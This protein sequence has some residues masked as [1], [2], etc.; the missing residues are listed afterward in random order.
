MSDATRTSKARKNPNHKKRRSRRTAATS[1]KHELYELSVQGPEAEGDFVDKAFR[2][3]RRRLARSIREDFCGTAIASA[4]WVKRRR[5]NTAI[6][7]DLDQSVLDWAARKLPERLDPEQLGRL[8]LR[9]ADVRT[10]R[11]PPVDCILAMNFSYY[12]FKTRQGLGQYFKRA[13][14]GLVEYGLFLIDAYGGSDSFLEMQERRKV[15]GF[16]YVWDQHSYNP[17]TGDAVNYIHFEFPDGT[18]MNK[19]FAYEWRLWTL[20]EIQELLYEAGFSKV[21]VYW[22][23]TGDD[24]EGNDEF[25]PSTVGEAC[26]GWI[27]YLAAEK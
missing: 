1:D 16:T 6:A 10:V 18:R 15:S 14:R 20:P 11:T 5:D 17:I 8:T 22:E 4:E 13:H 3:R 12:I 24:G 21:T 27:A 7:V 19:A 26:P 2:Q 9:R 23:G 25:D